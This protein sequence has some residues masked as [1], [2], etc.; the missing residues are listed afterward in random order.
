MMKRQQQPSV[1]VQVQ[2]RYVIDKTANQFYRTTLFRQ[3]KNTLAMK[4]ASDEK[5]LKAEIL[6]EF[7]KIWGMTIK[8]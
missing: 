2:H 5:L 8:R 4:R 1:E 6:A 3:S 7:H